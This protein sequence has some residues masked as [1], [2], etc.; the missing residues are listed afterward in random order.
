MKNSVP[1]EEIKRLFAQ[2]GA[3]TCDLGRSARNTKGKAT[4]SFETPEQARAAVAYLEPRSFYGAKLK[5]SQGKVKG[6]PPVANG[7]GVA[8]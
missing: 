2:V 5:V 3:R 6:R 1:E 4:A 8:T 7:S